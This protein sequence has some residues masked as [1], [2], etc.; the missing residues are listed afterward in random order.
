MDIIKLDIPGDTLEIDGGE[1][2]NNLETKL[3]IER[4]NKPGEFKFTTKY[5]ADLQEK[6]P[7][8]SYISHIDSTDIMCV[9]DHHIVEERDK[10]PVM[11]ITGRSLMK[12]FESRYQGAVGHAS[13]GPGKLPKVINNGNNVMDDIYDLL[14]PMV[15][16]S[17]DNTFKIGSLG[18]NES[19]SGDF[20]PTANRAF[21]R[22]PLY[23]TIID[24]LNEG[25][26]GLRFFRPG[27]WSASYYSVVMLFH[28]G[29]E[30]ELD[31]KEPMFSYDTGSVKKAEYFWSNKREITSAYVHGIWLHT[32]VEDAV[33]TGINKKVGGVYVPELDEQYTSLPTGATRTTIL[34]EM[35]TIGKALIEKSK[36]KTLLSAEIAQ[37]ENDRHYRVDYNIGDIIV[38]KGNY[39]VSS[40]MR[41]IEHVEAEDENGYSSYPML[42]PYESN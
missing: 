2:I 36:Q 39:N 32:L 18:I 16:N 21:P 15:Q 8:G 22:K 34:D 24:L 30:I 14:I 23:D 19:L 41:V 5:P 13:I 4:Y 28:R 27:P 26:I 10:P 40:T 25:D 7:V 11:T 37:G 33:Y 17:T 29:E 35:E 42:E 31:N 12:I 1:V 3:W 38:V 6:L 9:E 20:G